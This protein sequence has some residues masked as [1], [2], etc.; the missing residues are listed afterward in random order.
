[1]PN[2]AKDKKFTFNVQQ[3]H[4]TQGECQ[5]PTKCMTAMAIKEANPRASYVSV[6]ANE[7]RVTER[8]KPGAGKTLYKIYHVPTKLARRIHHHDDKPEARNLL[9]PF[10][11]TITLVDERVVAIITPEKR[12]KNAMHTKRTRDERKSLGLPAKDYRASQ[13]IKGI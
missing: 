7:I 3:H 4:I 1:M 11:A 6:R 12:A 9:R 10:E 8:G 5:S 13:R 2:I